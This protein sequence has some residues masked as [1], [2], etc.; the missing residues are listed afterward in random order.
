MPIAAAGWPGTIEIDPW[1]L[2][3]V[4]RCAWLAFD[5][6]DKVLGEK[7]YERPELGSEMPVRRP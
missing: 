1:Q 5:D 4:S 6:G 3:T 7:V 2:S